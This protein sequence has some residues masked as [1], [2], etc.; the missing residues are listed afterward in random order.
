MTQSPA[1]ADPPKYK[2][3]EAAAELSF[4]VTHGGSFNF[5]VEGKRESVAT[6]TVRIKLK[7][8]E[9]DDSAQ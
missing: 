8:T 5:F 3:G 2:L 4:E 1:A 7:S 9:L 6:Q